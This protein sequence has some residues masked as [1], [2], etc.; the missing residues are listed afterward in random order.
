MKKITIH[1]ALSELKTISKRIEKKLDTW[2]PI[3]AKQK[4]Q[5]VNNTTSDSDFKAAAKE[6]FQ[7]IKD[8]INRYENVSSAIKHSNTTTMVSVAG[9][10][11]SVSMA[12]IL[13]HGLDDRKRVLGHLKKEFIRVTGAVN[14]NNEKINANALQLAQAALS[15]DNVKLEDDDAIRITEPFINLNRFELIDPLDIKRIIKET[16]DEID[17]FESDVDAVLS[18][19]NAITFIEI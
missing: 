17:T 14:T 19:S 10:E 13:K 4:D 7:A 12:I 16:D 18:E 11:M 6:T 9:Q 8:L 5:L 2:V 1:R 15:K 3:G